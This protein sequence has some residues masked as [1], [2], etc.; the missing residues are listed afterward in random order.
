M[1]ARYSLKDG[2]LRVKRDNIARMAVLPRH[3]LVP[4]H[5]NKKDAVRIA[6]SDQ[7]STL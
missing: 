7:E 4:Q 1:R 2:E 5:P 6:R 3:D